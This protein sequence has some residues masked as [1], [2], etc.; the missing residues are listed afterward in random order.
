[1]QTTFMTGGG[2]TDVSWNT[3]NV[4]D[5][6][7][8]LDGMTV[9]SG[10]SGSTQVSVTSS[11]VLTLDCDTGAATESRN[12]WVGSG[13]T[14]MQG[15]MYTGQFNLN[16]NGFNLMSCDLS[17]D[18]G[19]S[20]VQTAMGLGGDDSYNGSIDAS[21]SGVSLTLDCLDN[22]SNA[23][24]RTLDLSLP[25]ITS[26]AATPAGVANVGDSTQLCWT[27][28]D[29]TGCRIEAGI[30]NLDNL[31]PNDCADVTLD[32]G[33]TT[34]NLHCQDDGGAQVSEQVYVPVG[35]GLVYFDLD[36]PA[37]PMGGGDVQVTWLAAN[38]LSCAL[39]KD[40]AP[41]TTGLSGDETINFTGNGALRLVCNDG[42]SDVIDETRQV[43]A[44]SQITSF[45]VDQF[46]GTGWNASW[47]T[48]GVND[49]ELTVDDGV[50]MPQTYSMLGADGSQ[51]GSYDQTSSQVDFSLSCNGSDGGNPTDTAQLLPVAITSF[52]A[53]STALLAAADVTFSWTSV[54]ATSCDLNGPGAP[55]TVATSGMT[56]IN[57]TDTSQFQLN[58]SDG[59]GGDRT[60]QITVAVGPEVT[61]FDV[62]NTVLPSGGGS[63]N[64]TWDTANVDACDVKFEGATIDSGL[65][66]TTSYTPM[67]SG[68]FSIDC[69]GANGPASAS[70]VVTVGPAVTSL[71]AWADSTSS[72]YVGWSS[73]YLDECS[74]QLVGTNDNQTYAQQPTDYPGNYFAYAGVSAEV[75]TVTVSCT[76]MEGDANDSTMVTLP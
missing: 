46:G 37:L 6:T 67:A 38:V 10:T 4:S 35:P 59:Q 51:F 22:D 18:D 33:S 1:M 70:Q 7:L 40:A 54:N 25:Q 2:M 32:Q 34:F 30:T 72:V 11:G 63:V 45:T 12:I 52:T 68:T 65:S 61:V 44:G 19:V 16:W 73:I 27:T 21:A 20:A 24:S 14:Y 75:V 47:D 71:N 69:T 43:Y 62:S 74:V 56:T 55:G 64:V 39:E 53:S 5:C 8:D 23:V 15:N 3:A 17:W 66:G 76:G 41:Y 58:C 13:I 9:G 29:A 42:A 48:A 50:Q 36:P 49:C 57:V 31:N 26:F 60:Q 28:V